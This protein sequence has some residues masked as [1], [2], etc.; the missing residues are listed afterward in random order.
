MYQRSTYKYK[1]T[2]TKLKGIKVTI[3][4]ETSCNTF[5]FVTAN[6]GYLPA[7]KDSSPLEDKI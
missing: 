1:N 2:K 4:K 5:D 6:I 7:C 3:H